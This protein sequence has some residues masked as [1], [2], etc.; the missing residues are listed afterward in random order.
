MT[1][2]AP[3]VVLT[4]L[5]IAS[6]S[7]AGRR[8]GALASGWLLA[9]PLTSGPIALFIS[10]ELG[11][12]AGAQAAA[13]SLIGATAQVAFSVA[14]AVASR[15]LDWPGCLLVASVAFAIAAAL[16]PPVAPAFLFVVALVAIAVGFP[17]V[18]STKSDV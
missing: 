1:F 2:L 3:K 11:T 6:A 7:L 14:Y 13:G 12:A 8:W 4:P 17:F 15:R 16:L 10:L 9:L 5:L 18:R